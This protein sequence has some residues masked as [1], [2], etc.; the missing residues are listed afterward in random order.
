MV[1]IK[2]QHANAFVASPDPKATAVLFYGPD[3]GLV[4]ER[5]QKLARLLAEREKPSGEIV[6]LDDSDLDNDPDRLSVE[7]LT[8][9]MFGG[10]KIVRATVGRRI[11]T[12][13]LKAILEGTPLAGWLIVEA[14]NLRPDEALRALFE[15]SPVAA[16][17]PCYADETRDLA[18]MLAEVL[19]AE[20]LSISP[21]AQQQLL[22]RL[23]ADR[24]LSR[25]EVEKLALYASAKGTIDVED[26]EAIVG[27]AAELAM[28][29][30]INAAALGMADRALIEC[31]R[32]VAAGES[33]QS[34]IAATQRH[35][36]R[37]HRSRLAVDNGRT[38]DDVIRQMRP[39][40][41]FKQR[42]AFE[43]QCRQWTAQRLQAA[44]SSIQTAAKAARL[45]SAMD[46][47][48]AERLLLDLATLGSKDGKRQRA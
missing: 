8:V 24:G 47:V 28:D 40:L 7:L 11:N 17:V 37:L 45:N 21:D 43:T 5:S 9:P 27:D 1:A 23:G 22:A 10:R 35:F 30:L 20:K 31:D 36:L 32:A 4:S 42:Q 38:L 25:S 16:A 29:R 41:H 33:A 34:I 14:G 18:G 12:P 13:A 19:A 3:A 48:L 15:K 39:P 46:A 2:A 6:R 26:V 44:L